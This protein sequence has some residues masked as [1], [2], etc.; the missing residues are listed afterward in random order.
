MTLYEADHKT[1]ILSTGPNPS[2][3][4]LE[5]GKLKDIGPSVRYLAVKRDEPTHETNKFTIQWTTNLTVFHSILVD[6]YPSPYPPP[7]PP[8][9]PS[10]KEPLL[11]C[12][13]EC[14]PEWLGSD[15]IRIR[16]W[17]DGVPVVDADLGGF[18][19][20]DHSG[21]TG[22]IPTYG[23]RYLYEIKIRVWEMDDSPDDPSNELTIP[24]LS[25]H[26]VQ[27]WD[28]SGAG[29]FPAFDFEDGIYT[30]VFNRRTYLSSK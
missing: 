17:A 19:A 28:K 1:E 12:E 7:G 8:T 25:E 29:T 23:F 14:D 26:R 5:G 21:L 24:T 13:N 2:K 3:M 30:V 9:V 18:N 4:T 20:D 16:M 15:H 22:L 10:A 11:T 6:G 27:P